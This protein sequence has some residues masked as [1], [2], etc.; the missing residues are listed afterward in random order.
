M[1]MFLKTHDCSVMYAVSMI[2]REQN[3][4]NYI[5]CLYQYIAFVRKAFGSVKTSNFVSTNLARK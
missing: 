2:A 3:Y 1:E 5:F 4:H